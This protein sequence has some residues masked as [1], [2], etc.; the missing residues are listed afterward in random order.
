MHPDRSAS[1]LRRGVLVLVLASSMLLAGCSG[2]P[3]PAPTSTGD[4]TPDI[5]T[6]GETPGAS[7]SPTPEPVADISI[8]VSCEDIYS[9]DMIALLEGENPPLNDPGVTMESTENPALLE[10]LHSG[11]Q[12]L[13]CSW[14]LPSSYGLATNVTILDEGQAD[15]VRGALTSGGFSCGDLDRGTV[16][17][18]QQGDE[19]NAFGESHYLRAN[20]WVS[21]RWINF[22]PRGYTEDIVST[23]WG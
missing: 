18:V 19:E 12:T 22:G 15:A 13:R 2:S 14:G 17:R 10:V 20:G 21:T 6:L 23:L 3:Q 11:A 7:T 16:C 4:P 8:P 9:P 5:T 1:L